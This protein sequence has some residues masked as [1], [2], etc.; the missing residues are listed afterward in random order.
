MTQKTNFLMLIKKIIN[1]WGW[2]TITVTCDF[3]FVRGA[4]NF[5]LTKVQVIMLA[6]TF[7][8]ESFKGFM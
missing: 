2:L 5:I 8:V 1:N 3:L 4:N 6:I 7:V